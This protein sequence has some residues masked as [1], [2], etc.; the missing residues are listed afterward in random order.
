MNPPFP[1]LWIDLHRSDAAAAASYFFRA[2]ASRVCVTFVG[3]FK[4]A[5]LL[6]NTHDSVSIMQNR[7]TTG[8]KGIAAKIV[9]ASQ[10]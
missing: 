8:Q 4:L 5:L 2:I 1:L 10:E 3:K 9:I 7:L 6:A